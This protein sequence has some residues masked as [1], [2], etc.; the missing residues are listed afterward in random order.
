M[1]ASLTSSTST[2]K[3]RANIRSSLPLLRCLTHCKS[4]RK[5]VVG[6][7]DCGIITGMFARTKFDQ[8]IFVQKGSTVLLMDHGA[9]GEAECTVGL[10]TVAS[11][12]VGQQRRLQ[13]RTSDLFSYQPREVLRMH[14]AQSSPSPKTTA[15]RGSSA[16]GSGLDCI[17]LPPGTAVMTEGI[18]IAHCI[19]LCKTN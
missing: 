11:R 12:P 2:L 15:L 5:T 6:I 9:C 18:N 8:F 14:G 10:V 4:K 13:H 7:K 16:I 1:D 19:G 17:A 3:T